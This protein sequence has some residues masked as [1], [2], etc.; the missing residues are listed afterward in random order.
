MPWYYG[1]RVTALWSINQVNNAWAYLSGGGV[2][3]WR[4]I[5]PANVSTF[6]SLFAICVNAHNKNSPVDVNL[7]GSNVIIEVYGW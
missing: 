6:Q 7:D 1:T 4:K 2:S 5:S 3:G